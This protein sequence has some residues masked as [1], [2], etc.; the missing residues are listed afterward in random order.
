M[1]TW[2]HA[3]AS[4]AKK[5]VLS[6]TGRKVAQ[7]AAA[8]ASR[9]VASGDWSKVSQ[10]QDA[11]RQRDLAHRF[12]R[13]VHGRLS[14]A[15]FLGSRQAHLVVWKDGVPLAAFPPV[16]GDLAEKAELRHVTEEDR[17][18][19]RPAQRTPVRERLPRLPGRGSPG[20]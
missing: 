4:T 13:Q 16:E 5:L 7:Q 20:E 18:D 2:T 6:P 3:A 8:A 10:W 11:R 1:P 17:F 14:E 9:R 15:V 12:A 19:P